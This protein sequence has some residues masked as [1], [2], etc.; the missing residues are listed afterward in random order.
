MFITLKKIVIE[1]A[2]KDYQFIGDLDVRFRW[3]SIIKS[4]VVLLMGIGVSALFVQLITEKNVNSDLIRVFLFLS[5]SIVYGLIIT[6]L[7]LMFY[8]KAEIQKSMD[9]FLKNKESA[10]RNK[11]LEEWKYVRGKTKWLLFILLIVLLGNLI[12][13]FLK[14]KTFLVD[15]K[16][17]FNLVSILIP[18]IVVTI[19]KI[20]YGDILLNEYKSYCLASIKNE[21]ELIQPT[22][23]TNT[24]IDS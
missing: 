14:Y 13:D 11:I 8:P 2:T 24:L 4:L 10:E 3:Y 12:N 22:S 16:T 17:F 23:D 20:D 19:M 21:K 1:A 18:G 7:F 9:E 5:F 6:T 15:I